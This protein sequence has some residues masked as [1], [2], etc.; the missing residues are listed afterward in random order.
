M[1]LHSGHESVHSSWY[2]HNLQ[3]L[4]YTTQEQFL[5]ENN[6]LENSSKLS[7]NF[8]RNNVLKS[9]LFPSD[10]G[11]NFKIMILCDHME[12]SFKMNFKDYRHKLWMIYF[13]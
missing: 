6:I 10:M 4:S 8:E 9:L 3:L 12:K 2:L 13:K 1:H 5:L 11:E 7:D